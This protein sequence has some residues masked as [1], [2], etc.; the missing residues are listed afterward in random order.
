MNWVPKSSRQR[1]DGFALPSILIASI[2][3]L[4]VLVAAIQAAVSTRN[5]LQDQHYS[6]LAREAAESGL[7]MANACLVANEYVAIWTDAKPLRPN[8]DCA[9]NVQ[10]SALAYVLDNSK[11]R[12]GFTVGA[13][14]GNGAGTQAVLA[15]G[16]L[17]LLRTST[18]GVWRSYS[19]TQ[20]SVIGGALNQ[21]YIV[22]GYSAGGSCPGVYFFTFGANGTAR[23]VGANNCGQI[24]K[25]DQANAITPHTVV[26]PNGARVATRENGEPLI[27]ADFLS[28]GGST[29]IIGTDGNAYIAGVNNNGSA[30][31]G[32]TTPSRITSFTRFGL[33]AGQKAVYAV[34]SSTNTYVITESGYVYSSGYCVDGQLGNGT[35]G[36]DCIPAVS[37]VRMALPTPSQAN[38]STI[39]VSIYLDGQSRYMIMKD[40]SVYAWGA[41]AGG[42]L[43]LGDTTI[44]PTPAKVPG[45]GGSTGVKALRV[46]TTGGQT[47]IL[48]DDGVVRGAGSNSY[49]ILGRGFVDAG[50]SCVSSR[51]VS[52][53]PVLLPPTASSG[54]KLVDV[55]TDSSHAMF[56]TDRGQVFTS[57][58]NEAGQLGCG[59][60]LNGTACP[61]TDGTSFLIPYALPT[62]VRGASIYATSS[63]TSTGQN[64]CADNT[65]A[66]GSN[67]RV[68]GAG[69]NTHGQLGN[70][71]N[72]ANSASCKEV[73]G[74][75][76][77]MSVIDGVNAS[78]TNVVSGRGTTVVRTSD[79][80]IYTVGANESGQLGDGTTADS[81]VPKRHR[82]VNTGQP[83]LIY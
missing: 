40:G 44:R 81:S 45:Y 18:G 22:L 9:G 51:C 8:T 28:G 6:Q 1:A 73:N 31:I 21:H 5:A 41:N 52:F 53:E 63:R 59:T 3:M 20:I 10:S 54:S 83:L 72:L 26:L 67:G 25:G 30:G 7:A 16:K 48:S 39:P 71:C 76:V 36:D 75:P 13:V 34:T 65:F 19:E 62:G 56:L 64:A 79:G 14:M 50:P 32:T 23:G 33:L 2:V 55:R 15:E 4:M 80:L 69:C 82:F 12:T 11:V 35:S 38:S 74:T 17:E 70:G 61:E 24:G 42:Q 37:P 60:P 68:Y 57:G 49:G 27:F 77:A 47:F 29:A 46:E 78:A 66:V 43:G 58:R